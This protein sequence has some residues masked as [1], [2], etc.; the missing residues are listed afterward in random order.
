[1]VGSNSICMFPTQRTPS[2]TKS[3]KFN[4]IGDDKNELIASDI[5]EEFRIMSVY[6]A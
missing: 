4:N 3:Y 2:F 5:N 6:L 1:M